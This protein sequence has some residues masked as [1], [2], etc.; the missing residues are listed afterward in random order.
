MRYGRRENTLVSNVACD[1]ARRQ[2]ARYRSV[3]DE[4]CCANEAQPV[5]WIREI[6]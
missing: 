4:D 3:E 6:I 1:V 5:R 2:Q